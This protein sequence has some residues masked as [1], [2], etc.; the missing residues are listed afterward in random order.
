MKKHGRIFSENIRHTILGQDAQNFQRST[1][2]AQ[3]GGT[4]PGAPQ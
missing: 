3:V 4:P 1:F 2:N